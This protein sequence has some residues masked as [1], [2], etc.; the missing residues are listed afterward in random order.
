M[1]L[2]HCGQVPPVDCALL[3]AGLALCIDQIMQNSTSFSWPGTDLQIDVIP[4]MT[5]R[6]YHKFREW[7][8]RPKTSEIIANL[9]HPIPCLGT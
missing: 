5:D 9:L 3:L 4:I 7:L 6:D 8:Q 1:L 2:L